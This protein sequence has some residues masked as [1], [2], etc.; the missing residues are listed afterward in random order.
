M[1]FSRYLNG[2]SANKKPS[3]KRVPICQN[4]L[5]FL[6]PP[7]RCIFGLTREDTKAHRER[8]VGTDDQYG[9]KRIISTNYW[10][11]HKSHK[12]IGSGLLESVYHRCMEIEFKKA[13][14]P[15]ESEIFFPVFYDGQ[16][17]ESGYRLDM[18]VDKR[19]VVELK[20][21]E[22]ITDVHKSQTLSYIRM[23]K[24]EL[25]LLLK[26]QRACSKKTEFIDL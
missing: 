13:E 8:G 6:L 3:P 11:R 17:I 4:A 7:I 23:G 12:S 18:L 9:I 19:I 15:F 26:F 20:S 10:H 25:G 1:P 2:F 5:N 14:I 22:H 16:K 24:F 21:V